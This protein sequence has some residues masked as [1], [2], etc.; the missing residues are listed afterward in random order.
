[1][2]KKKWRK[3]RGTWHRERKIGSFQENE[4]RNPVEAGDPQK[5]EPASASR[6]PRPCF[7][8]WNS[9][10]SISWFS[11]SQSCGHQIHPFDGDWGGFLF[12]QC[13]T[14]RELMLLPLFV[15]TYQSWHVKNYPTLGCLSSTRSALRL[16]HF[17]HGFSIWKHQNL[18]SFFIR[19]IPCFVIIFH[20]KK[21]PMWSIPA[22][23]DE[24]YYNIYIYIY[25]YNHIY[26]YIYIIIYI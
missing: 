25:I 17:P 9:A 11:K 8:R 20:L 13:T 23:I 4:G 2:P 7:W 5:K 10:S 6:D 14:S 19:I 3:W 22:F 26:T 24:R 21:L 16:E 18:G 15:E 1:V 12:R